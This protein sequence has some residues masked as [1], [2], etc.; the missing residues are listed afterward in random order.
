MFSLV[1][2]TQHK[3]NKVQK[4][5]KRDDDL[6]SDNLKHLSLGVFFGV[7]FFSARKYLVGRC[8]ICGKCI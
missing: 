8:K 7:S 2:N 5:K 6:Y 1:Y 3:R 4:K